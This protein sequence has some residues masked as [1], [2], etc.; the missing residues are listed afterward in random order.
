[1]KVVD[2]A[3]HKVHFDN[4]V[5]KYCHNLAQVSFHVDCIIEIDSV[6]WFN[7]SDVLCQQTFRK[8]HFRRSLCNRKPGILSA[9]A[10]TAFH[11]RFKVLQN[12][13]KTTGNR[14][15]NFFM[16]RLGIRVWYESSLTQIYLLTFFLKWR[17]LCLLKY[18]LKHSWINL[19]RYF[20]YPFF[21]LL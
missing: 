18:K 14:M 20:Q 9:S 4:T 16:S 21:N 7:N 6:H 10:G 5:Y 2:F 11:R 13:V 15:L 3:N 1:M 17:I 8:Q 12:K 19:R